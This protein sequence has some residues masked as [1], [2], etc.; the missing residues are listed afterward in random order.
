MS[1]EKTEHRIRL[2]LCNL[3]GLVLDVMLNR[4]SSRLPF[5]AVLALWA[6]LPLLFTVWVWRVEKT[7]GR[8]TKQFSE[9]PV[10]YVLMFL[11]FIPFAWYATAT[12]YSKFQHDRAAQPTI[13]VSKVP[14]LPFVATAQKPTVDASSPASAPARK[15]KKSLPENLQPQKHTIRQPQTAPTPLPT[16]QVDHGFLNNAPNYGDQRIEDNR[17]Y[18]VHEPLPN[19]VGLT[20]QPTPAMPKPEHTADMPIADRQRQL[21]QYQMRLEGEQGL[22]ENPGLTLSFGVDAPFAN[23]KFLVRCD[24]P[25][26]ATNILFSRDS[27]TSFSGGSS[28]PSLFHTD[29]PRVVVFGSGMLQLLTTKTSVILTVRSQDKDPLGAA[30]VEPYAQ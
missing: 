18:G 6:V 24:R 28:N 11:T 21:G 1:D 7:S 30:T 20:T 4:Y 5:L 10:S 2:G 25:C 27:V 3:A 13:V 26:I 16:Q 22:T 12:V 23:P 9:H 19:I 17:Q 8:L 15:V 29:N 14:Q